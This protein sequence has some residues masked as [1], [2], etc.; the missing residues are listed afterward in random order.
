MQQQ[1]L[2]A[3]CDAMCQFP[4]HQAKQ[5]I[6]AELGSEPAMKG[7]HATA[8]VCNMQPRTIKMKRDSFF[9]VELGSAP[10]TGLPG[11]SWAQHPFSRCYSGQSWAQRLFVGLTLASWHGM[12]W[13]GLARGGRGWRRLAGRAMKVANPV[14]VTH[15]NLGLSRSR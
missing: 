11:R 14:I 15:D 9:W 6:V 10:I 12:G 1:T 8:Q 2:A 7:V 5:K 13:A 4:E 3:L